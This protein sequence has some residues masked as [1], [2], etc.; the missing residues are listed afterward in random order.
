MA[1][2]KGVIN[3]VM[4][5][6]EEVRSAVGQLIKA[7][8]KQEPDD[9]TYDLSGKNLADLNLMELIMAMS[10]IAGY[11]EHRITDKN[12]RKKFPL[13]YSL[14]LTKKANGL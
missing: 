6:V 2:T 11:G 10:E 5:D 7:V 8:T 9:W 1:E 3:G 14:W 4:V 12:R 13:F